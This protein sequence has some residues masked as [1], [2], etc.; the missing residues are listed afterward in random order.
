[1]EVLVL[2]DFQ[3]IVYL[4]HNVFRHELYERN[5]EDFLAAVLIYSC[6]YEWQYLLKLRLL[7]FNNYADCL[8]IISQ[9]SFNLLSDN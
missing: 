8:H 1:M 9:I 4:W 2:R 7:L 3:P 6:R 5:A